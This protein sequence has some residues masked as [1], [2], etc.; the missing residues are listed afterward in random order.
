MSAER[1][2]KIRYV[3][4]THPRTSEIAGPILEV[5][6]NPYEC[7]IAVDTAQLPSVKLIR[8]AQIQISESEM[9][10]QRQFDKQYHMLME[11]FEMEIRQ[12]K[13]QL[14]VSPDINED[15]PYGLGLTAQSP[16]FEH[17]PTRNAFRGEA[18]ALRSD[19][20]LGNFSNDGIDYQDEML[21][22]HFNII[23]DTPGLG[24]ANFAQSYQGEILTSKSAEIMRELYDL[25][26]RHEIGDEK[27]DVSLA[28]SNLTQCVNSFNVPW[29]EKTFEHQKFKAELFKTEMCRSWAK[30]GLCPYGESCRF[31]HGLRELRM[32]PKPH[33]KYK[34]EMCKKFLSGFC[35]YGPRCNFVHMPYEQHRA[36]INRTKC[37]G[38]SEDQNIYEYARAMA[39]ISD[40]SIPE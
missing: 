40:P 8:K 36:M 11:K 12:M 3:D 22:G 10:Q 4:R 20:L 2:Q 7:K 18:S 19:E 5:G 33:W 6:Q 15:I 26:N 37:F 39:Q 28:Y 16:T 25:C 1:I 14:G 32:R 30:F 31:A 13:R 35:P 29:G 21:R 17:D 27:Q 38:N 9:E 34:T 23:P 24:S